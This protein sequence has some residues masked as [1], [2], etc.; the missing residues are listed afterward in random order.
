MWVKERYLIGTKG[1]SCTWSLRTIIW[2]W[3]QKCSTE[4]QVL[5]NSPKCEFQ[6]NAPVYAG[7][8]NSLRFIGGYHGGAVPTQNI[9]TSPQWEWCELLVRMLC[10]AAR[11][12]SFCISPRPPDV[13]WENSVIIARSFHVHQGLLCSACIQVTGWG[14]AVAR[15]SG[16][17]WGSRNTRLSRKTWWTSLTVTTVLTIT[18][19]TRL[20][21]KQIGKRRTVS[22]I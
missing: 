4:N 22:D 10:A 18:G 7:C 1:N 17:T 9:L 6:S 3:K 2:S 16:R 5:K 19:L 13:F 21:W 14:V 20:T 8:W 11:G 12:W 15:G